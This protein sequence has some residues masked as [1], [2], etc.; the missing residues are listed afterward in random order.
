MNNEPRRIKALMDIDIFSN[1]LLFLLRKN[2]GGKNYVAKIDWKEED[3]TRFINP[4]L[5][6]EEDGLTL[7][8][9]ESEQKRFFNDLIKDLKNLGVLDDSVEVKSL[10]GKLEATEKH[11]EDMRKLVFE[12][13]KIKILEE[14]H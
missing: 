5:M 14:R 13:P 10:E 9:E 8:I 11:L 6:S 3:Q 2:V 1:R 12:E 4:R 7:V